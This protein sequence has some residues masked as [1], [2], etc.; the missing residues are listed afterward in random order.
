MQGISLHEKANT[1]SYMKTNVHTYIFACK[2]ECWG[3]CLFH[4]VTDYFLEY[5]AKI[6]IYFLPSSTVSKIFRDGSS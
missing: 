3:V 1:S 4:E 5:E 2:Y 6:S